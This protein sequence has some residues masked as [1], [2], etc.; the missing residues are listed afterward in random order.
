MGSERKSRIGGVNQGQES[1]EQMVES[2]GW[3]IN[4]FGSGA[5]DCV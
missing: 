1:E 4:G 3:N 2:K 5:D